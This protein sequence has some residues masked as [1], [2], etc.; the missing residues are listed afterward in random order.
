[1]QTICT[2]LQTDDHTNTS[3]LIIFTGRMLFQTPNQWV[4]KHWRHRNSISNS[5]IQRKSKLYTPEVLWQFFANSQEF[6]NQIHQTM[7]S[8]AYLQHSSVKGR[9]NWTK[10]CNFACI[11]T[12]NRQVKLQLK[13]LIHCGKIAGKAQGC[14]FFRLPLCMSACIKISEV[15][16]YSAIDQAS[17]KPS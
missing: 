7:T 8:R 5:S 4:S 13:I 12:C 15:E 2:S 16:T 14:N 17:P 9:D 1:M 6:S 11:W 3:S 10:F